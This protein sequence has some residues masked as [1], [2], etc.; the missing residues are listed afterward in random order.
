MISHDQKVPRLHEPDRRR[1]MR[2]Q[3]QPIQNG[4][5]NRPR[6]ELAA[7]IATR[8]DGAVDRRALGFR[9]G[10]AAARV[11]GCCMIPTALSTDL[12]PSS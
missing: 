1:V 6:Q 12:W 2:R 4:G 7:H 9:K 5:V 10:P 11:E 8:V 3:K